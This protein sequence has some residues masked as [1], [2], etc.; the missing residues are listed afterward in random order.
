MNYLSTGH[1]V[2]DQV[3]S[4][5]FE[6]NVIPTNWFSTFK[7]E[8][9]KPDTIG[10]FLLSEIVYWYRPTVVR[11]EE[12][13][14]ILGVKKKFKSDLLQRSYQS[15]AD[16][17]G[18]SKQQVKESLDR[19]EKIGIVKRH[20]RT[21]EANSQKY[22]N[23][24]FIELVAPL[25]FE[26]TTLS[27]S[28]LGLSPFEKVDPPN[29]KKG[30]LPTSERGPSQSPEGDPPHFKRGTNTETTT[31]ITTESVKG[32]SKPKFSPKKFLFDLGVSDQTATEFL[33]LRARKKKSVTS[34]VIRLV[35]NQAKIANISLE[36]ALQIVTV[37]GW[38]SFKADWQWQDTYAELDQLENPTDQQADQEA[39][40]IRFQPEPMQFGQGLGQ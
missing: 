9:G 28:K 31:E 18:F 13:G 30:S 15:F 14:Q 26:L 6:G 39:K 7:M 36:R 27:L 38:D 34:T 29:L 10:I 40:P 25:L 1:D 19:L 35:V 32:N 21:V 11:D 3:G 20:F 37:R 5:H 12:T 2:V 8:N 23:V 4:V 24:L 17:F 16:Q 33:E 22:N